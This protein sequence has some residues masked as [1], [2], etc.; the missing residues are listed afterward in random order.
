MSNFPFPNQTPRQVCF[1]CHGAGAFESIGYETCW[2]CVGTGR[3]MNSEC[4]TSPCLHCNATG[5]VLKYDRKTCH[6]CRG[7]G[8]LE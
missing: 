2:R 4:F 7:R 3:D 1:N 5:Q 6:V 8:Y